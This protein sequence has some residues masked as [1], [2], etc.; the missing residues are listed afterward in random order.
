MRRRLRIIG[1]RR[2]AARRLRRCAVPG[3]RA[4]IIGASPS[5]APVPPS[6]SDRQCVR[7]TA[8]YC[9]WRA[10]PSRSAIALFPSVHG[11]RP[12]ADAGGGAGADRPRPPRSRLP[13]SRARRRTHRLRR[14]SRP[15]FRRR[16]EIAA[17]IRAGRFR[18]AGDGR[19]RPR[20]STYRRGRTV[21]AAILARD[22][23]GRCA[24]DDSRT[25]R[26]RGDTRR[27]VDDRR[28]CPPNR[29]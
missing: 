15:P 4:A 6:P 2:L 13:L 8:P 23:R 7:Y 17:Q 11:P 21:P 25:D 5:A 16:E 10:S 22:G 24:R 20:R 12:V 14:R 3:A 18:G 1:Y 26:G 29:C 9:S 28:R 19:D 27:A